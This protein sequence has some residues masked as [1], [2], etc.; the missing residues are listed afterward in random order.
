LEENEKNKKLKIIYF[1]KKNKLEEIQREYERTKL[2]F[3]KVK[4]MKKM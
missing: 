1:E 2:Q 3:E 4:N